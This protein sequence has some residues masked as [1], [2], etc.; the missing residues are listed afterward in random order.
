ME[1]T[2]TPKNFFLQIGII[3]TL[4]AS[5]VSFLTFLFNLIDKTFPVNSGGFSYYAYDGYG[6]AI[7]F[8]ISTLIVTFPLFIW[9]S[10]LYR[11]S[12]VTEP[13]LK[14]S[15]IRKWLLYFTLFLAG[16]TIAID[17]IVLIN[18]FLR[19]SDITT[20]FLLKVLVVLVVAAK[21]FYFYLKDI[22]GYWEANPAKAKQVAWVLSAVVLVA[23]V[24]G[25]FAIGSPVNQQKLSRDNERV[26]ALQDIQWQIVNFYQSKG[27]LPAALSDL[28]DPISGY[29]VPIDPATGVSYT[30]TPGTTLDF[31]LCALF[32]TVSSSQEEM[33][34]AKRAIGASP[35]DLYM[36]NWS[37]EIGE[38]CF[39]R[40][41]DPERYPVNPKPVR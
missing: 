40:N 29:I 41:I 25:F 8:A 22:K 30:Y 33:S 17:L 15:K 31:K 20:A 2:S 11:R 3:I 19:G 23:V 6:S 10:R 34:Q 37:H 16:L 5:I 21:V 18:S 28:T 1:T 13:G 39:D 12:V 27:R 35:V 24:G 7:R 38:K 9:L 36:T 26:S 4:Y 14:E 32:E